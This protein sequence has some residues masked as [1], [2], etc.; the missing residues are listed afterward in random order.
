MKEVE[1]VQLYMQVYN[2]RVIVL[3]SHHYNRWYNLINSISFPFTDEP[4]NVGTCD[5]KLSDGEIQYHVL[6][7]MM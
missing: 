6:V 5:N 7:P 2:I 1:R 3:T 4:E